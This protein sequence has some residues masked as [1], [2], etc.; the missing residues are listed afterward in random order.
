MSFNF[1]MLCEKCNQ[2]EAGEQRLCY[3]CHLNNGICDCCEDIID[4]NQAVY[5]LSG[6]VFLCQDCYEQHYFTCEWCEN[7][8]TYDSVYLFNN[9]DYCEYCIDDMF[10][11]QY[12][13]CIKEVKE[14]KT[15]LFAEESTYIDALS[16]QFDEEPISFYVNENKIYIKPKE[17]T[18]EFDIDQTWWIRLNYNNILADKDI[19][20]NLKYSISDY[21]KI[22]NILL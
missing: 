15:V 5:N 2:D 18:S 1:F 9:H 3:D 14:G 8:Y 17:Y 16:N 22:D 21:M 12:N 11:M 6:T 19:D 20:D 4:N 7:I 13:N 10:N